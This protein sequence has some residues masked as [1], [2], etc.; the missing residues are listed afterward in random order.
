[1]KR[2]SSRGNPWHDAKG[3]FCHGPEA[4]VDTWGNPIS[5]E[6][7]QEWVK[8][9]EKDDYSQQTTKRFAVQIDLQDDTITKSFA[10]SDIYKKTSEI[11]AIQVTKRQQI[12]TVL[13]SGLLETNNV[14]EVGDYIVTNPDGEQYIVK[15]ENFTKKY[16]E[17]EKSRLVNGKKQIV[18][19]PKGKIRA[20]QNNTGK[21]VKIIAPWGEEQYGE[22]NCYFAAPCDESG[23]IGTDRY[24]IGKEEFDNTYKSQRNEELKEKYNL[25][26]KISDNNVHYGLKGDATS[27]YIRCGGFDKNKI[28]PI[29]NRN[30]VPISDKPLGGV[31][32]SASNVKFGWNEWVEREGMTGWNDKPTHVIVNGARIIHIYDV[33]TIEKLPKTEH[34]GIDFEKVS[35]DFDGIEL[36]LSESKCGV[37]QKLYGWDCD[38][39]LIFNPNVFY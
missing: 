36:H 12:D 22:E 16:T 13:K 17:T 34:G 10:K 23:N 21:K 30:G 35:K 20:F 29:K 14:A 25:S 11:T 5:D 18:F 3:K 6:Q 28:E 7:R 9:S 15:K 4:K 27:H 1:M 19:T 24:I 38:S 37:M 8:H 26:Y 39:T 32:L 2:K 33:E 31:W